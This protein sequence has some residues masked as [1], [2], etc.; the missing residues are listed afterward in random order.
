[1]TTQT[2]QPETCEV[3]EDYE[4][5]GINSCEVCEHFAGCR[6]ECPGDKKTC[7]VF[8]PASDS[9]GD[10]DAETG[11]QTNFQFP[12]FDCRLPNT[13]PVGPETNNGSIPPR[14]GLEVTEPDVRRGSPPPAAPDSVDEHVRLVQHKLRGLEL[15][16]ALAI[17]DN[18]GK[19]L[20]ERILI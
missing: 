17:R 18:H 20:A 7:E 14:S 3:C 6:G 12:N 5:G 13:R 9:H 1:M 16:A 8:C 4:P 10:C 11:D 2:E 19:F 15:A